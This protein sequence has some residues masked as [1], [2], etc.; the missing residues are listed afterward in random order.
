MAVSTGI[1]IPA[2]GTTIC[3]RGEN[4]EQAPET[5]PEAEEVNGDESAVNTVQDPGG[6]ASVSAITG[7]PV[8]TRAGEVLTG[9]G[10]SNLIRVPRVSARAPTIA[11]VQGT[12]AGDTRAAARRFA[13]AE[14]TVTPG[15]PAEAEVTVT[16]AATAHAPEVTRHREKAVSNPEVRGEA[17]AEA[18]V[19]SVTAAS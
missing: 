17:E 16:P 8:P 1:P 6:S 7:R 5:D 11:N 3:D 4:T 2:G 12:A 10:R 15:G 14:V 9:A 13:E 18:E 19:K